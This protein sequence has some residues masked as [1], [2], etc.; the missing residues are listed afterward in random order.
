MQPAIELL[1]SLYANEQD[2]QLEYFERGFKTYRTYR[3]YYLQGGRNFT[4]R[5]HSPDPKMAICSYA[6]SRAAYW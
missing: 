5:D 2:K 6:P 1:N 4:P 3:R